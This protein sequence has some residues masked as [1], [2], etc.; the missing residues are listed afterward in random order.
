V[1]EA[2]F[3]P[4]TAAQ[5]IARLDA[6]GIAN[7]RM[8]DMHE[9]WAHPQLAARRRWTDVATSAGRV[10]ALVPP[11]VAPEPPPRMDPIPALGEHTAAILRELGCD[12]AA[13]GRLRDAGVV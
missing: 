11:G 9:V 3:R 2:A 8:N 4:L 7:A 12:D 13:I 5:V 1:I 6:A 10:P